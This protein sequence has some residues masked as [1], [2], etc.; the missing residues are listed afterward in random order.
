M[1]KEM[2]SHEISVLRN[3]FRRLLR[4][5]AHINLRKIIQKTHPADLAVLFRYFTGPEQKTLFDLM[6]ENEHT[7][8]FLTELDEAI[9]ITILENEEPKRIAALFQNLGSTSQK[10]QV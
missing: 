2:F 10:F 5:N 6:I 7:A 3:T 1:R 4:R 8:E 9:I